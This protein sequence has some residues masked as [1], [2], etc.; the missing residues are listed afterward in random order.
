M[1]K[2]NKMGMSDKQLME[3]RRARFGNR[4]PKP[5]G[6]DWEAFFDKVQSGEYTKE[7]LKAELEQ[8]TGQ[9]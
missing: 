2:P 4:K 9:G 8:L 5:L 7:E 3:S 6:E 1:S